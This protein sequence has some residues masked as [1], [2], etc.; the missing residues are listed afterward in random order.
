MIL[1]L[2]ITLSLHMLRVVSIKVSA[3]KTLFSNI[4]YSSMLHNSAV[5]NRVVAFNIIIL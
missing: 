5:L 1:L 4:F 2:K 3:Q